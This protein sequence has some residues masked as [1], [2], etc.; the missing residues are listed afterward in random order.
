MID[1]QRYAERFGR[2]IEPNEIVFDFDNREFGFEAVH[3]TG[4]RLYQAGYCFEIWYA[5]NQKSPHIHIKKILYLDLEGEQLKEYKKLVLL[6]YSPKEYQ[7]YLD[8]KLTAKHRIA[9]ENKPHYKYK[10]EKKLLNIWNSELSNYAEQDLLKSA[11]QIR[12]YNP[13]SLPVSSNVNLKLM[14]KNCLWL[15]DTIQK[16]ELNHSER[17]ALMFLYLK[18]GEEGRKRLF[19]ILSTKKHFSPTKTNYYLDYYIKQ[20]K[21]FGISCKKLIEQGL[22]SCS[23]CSYFKINQKK[24]QNDKSN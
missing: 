9:E 3:L 18:S 10:T 20:G 14:E 5:E 19:E 17:T 22:C 2:L 16:E 12:T 6:K 8:L 13:K 1:K 4:V 24:I 21:L 15:R 11:K 23:D 7:E